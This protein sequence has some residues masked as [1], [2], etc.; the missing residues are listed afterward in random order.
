MASSKNTTHSALI[1][2]LSYTLPLLE[3][4]LVK[5]ITRHGI[6]YGQ[7]DFTIGHKILN[8]S[9]RYKISINDILNLH[10]QPRDIYSYYRVNEGSLAISSPLIEL[11]RCRDGS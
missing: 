7:M 10:F 9:S 2:D 5:I 11:L 4:S 8:C 6:I 1:P 3:S